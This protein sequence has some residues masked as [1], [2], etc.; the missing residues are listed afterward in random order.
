M[1][2]GP[3]MQWMLSSTVAVQDT[4]LWLWPEWVRCMG[5]TFG[6]RKEGRDRKEGEG[7]MGEIGREGSGVDTGTNKESLRQRRIGAKIHINNTTASS[8]T[9]GDLLLLFGRI[10]LQHHQQQGKQVFI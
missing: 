3:T 1:N 8:D 4:A 7:G 9:M 2:P 5:S 6:I 10:A